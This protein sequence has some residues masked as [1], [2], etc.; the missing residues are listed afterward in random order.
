MLGLS[1][2]FWLVAAGIGGC[3]RLAQGLDDAR[4]D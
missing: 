4:H 3:V 1:G 2:L